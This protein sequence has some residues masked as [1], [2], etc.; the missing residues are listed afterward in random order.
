M[1]GSFGPSTDD[2]EDYSLAR[3]AAKLGGA[4]EVAFR[5]K[6][7]SAGGPAKL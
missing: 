4:I 2:L 7:Q 5:V 6:D 3:Y 1:H